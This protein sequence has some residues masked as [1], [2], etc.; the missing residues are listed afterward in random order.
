[1]YI[2]EDCTLVNEKVEN[3]DDAENLSS[4]IW[5]CIVERMKFGLV[6]E[7]WGCT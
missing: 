1:M 2:G 6:K 7:S 4:N 5:W 3:Y